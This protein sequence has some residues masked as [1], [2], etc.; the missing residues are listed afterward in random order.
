[1]S[2]NGSPTPS[3]AKTIGIVVGSVLG[4][5]L[6][7]IGALLFVLLHY[8]QKKNLFKKKKYSVNEPRDS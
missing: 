4:T 7:T 1:M 5:G 2:S 8:W 6:L 3:S